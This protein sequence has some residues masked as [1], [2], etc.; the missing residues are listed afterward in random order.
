MKE[1][2]SRYLKKQELEIN[3]KSKKALANI[4]KLFN[5]RNDPIK[6]V[7]DNCSIIFKLKEKRLEKNQLQNH[8]RQI[9]NAKVID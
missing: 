5:G 9:L 8:E 7:D 6:F 2:F 3:L 4:N 1:G